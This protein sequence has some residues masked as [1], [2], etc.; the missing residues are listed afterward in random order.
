MNQW[1]KA[2]EVL[3]KGGV[4]II[5]SDSSYGIAALAG[6]SKAVDRLYQIKKRDP[7]KPSLII[8]GSLEQAEE[9]VIMTPLA[10]KLIKQYWP[11]GLTIILEAKQKGA[12]LA[13]RLPDKAELQQLAREVGPFILPSANF[14]G[15]ST[16]F[17]KEAVDPKLLELVDYFLDEP[18][19]GVEV[20]TLIDARG[21]KPIILRQGAVLLNRD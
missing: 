8:I 5:P 15:Q 7:G 3:K 12:T 18:T 10:E 6:N 2:A 17:S 20:S 16:P 21:D 14:N 9:L 19:D 13:V 11:G 4:I 1:Q